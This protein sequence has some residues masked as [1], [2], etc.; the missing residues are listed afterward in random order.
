MNY[1]RVTTSSMPKLTPATN[2]V[3]AGLLGDY[4]WVD[5]D[6]KGR[7]HIVWADT[8]GK[9]NP[10]RPPRMHPSPWCGAAR[11]LQVDGLESR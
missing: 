7:T 10:N 5:V 1:T 6:S 2:P 8:R 4:M 3:Q 9:G 11:P